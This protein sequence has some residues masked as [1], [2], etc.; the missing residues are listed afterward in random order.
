MT[1][2]PAATAAT[3]DSMVLKRCGMEET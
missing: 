2:F 3:A 1:T